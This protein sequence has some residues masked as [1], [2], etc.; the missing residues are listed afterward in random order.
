[1]AQE[2]KRA[3]TTSIMQHQTYIKYV[4]SHR[5]KDR[6]LLV[7]QNLPAHQFTPMAK[8]LGHA[9]IRALGVAILL[10]MLGKLCERPLEGTG[11][12]Q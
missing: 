9:L 5:L 3:D 4:E 12:N 11:F 7:T 10:T 2:S 8:N 6:A 1:M